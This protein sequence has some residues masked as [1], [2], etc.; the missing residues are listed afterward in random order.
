MSDPNNPYG[1]PNPYGDESGSAGQGGQNPY[2]APGGQPYSAPGSQ[3]Y[4]QP[5]QGDGFG[6]PGGQEA[7]TDGVSIASFVLSLLCCTG[8]IGLIL[9]FVGLSR[10]K[11]GQ[12]KGRW[13]AIAGIVLGALGVL[14]AIGA[15]IFVAF[16]ANT[17]VTPG[18][19]EVGQCV[20]IE[21]E[22]NT[23]VLTKTEC[24]DEHDGEIV[25]VEEV[26]SDNLD[27]VDTAMVGYCAE[28]IDGETLAEITS[29]PALTVQA[30]TEDPDDIAVG[31]HLVCYVEG[32]DLTEKIS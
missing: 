12:R 29:D 17:I 26:T 5:Y 23:V 27:A 7:K 21:E 14:G 20:D 8:L 19:A 32:D 15:G 9:G 24:T 18:N 25:G 3:P 13:A 4:G 2:G 30:V 22:N 6:T 10:T 11:N 31:D 1:P 16:V 28:I